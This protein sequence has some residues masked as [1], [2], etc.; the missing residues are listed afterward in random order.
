MDQGGTVLS[1]Y[2][3][4]YADIEIGSSIGEG[5]FGTVYKGTLRRRTKSARSIDGKDSGVVVAVK[6]MRVDK[7]APSVLR[8]FK[9]E[10]LARP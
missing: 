9:G 8:K 10:I 5:S 6:T 2:A 3:I 1:Q 7:V 4:P